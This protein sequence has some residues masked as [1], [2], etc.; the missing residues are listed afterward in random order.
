VK[1]QPPVPTPK[2]Q[3]ALR[4][5]YENKDT[6]L[7]MAWGV[8]KSVALATAGWLAATSWEP[9]LD[10]CFFAPT[11][12]QLQ[13][14]IVKA[15]TDTVARPGAYRLI[16]SGTNP[17]I[18]I[19][20]PGG[21]TS[22]IYLISGEE[23]AAARIEGL[24][25]AWVAGDELQDISRG[26]WERVA[27]RARL[28]AAK[29]LR[30]FGGGLPE[31]G[32]WLE[33]VLVID[34]QPDLVWVRGKSE[35]NPHNNDDYVPN[36][37]RTL[38]PNLFRSRALGEFAP[39]S[40]LVHPSFSRDK[41]VKPC[42]YTP[43]F[44]LI[45]GQDFNNSPMASVL[46]QDVGGETRVIG[47]IVEPGTTQD[48]AARLVKWC[49]DR[50]VNHRDPTQCVVVPDASGSARNHAGTSD[51]GLLKAAG[52]VLDGPAANPAIRDRDNAVLARLETA[53]GVR[54]LALDPSCKKTIAALAGLKHK[55][56]DRSEH[57]HP[58]DALGYPIH[59]YHPIV[60]ST[61]GSVRT[62]GH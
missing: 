12:G 10:G 17:R 1:W 4:A 8:G 33:D 61:A 38:P 23:H 50:K 62:T 30:R 18:E 47:E 41:H 57:S 25:L 29:R 51:H 52:F 32:T 22:T 55:G 31:S 14:T 11:L 19:P 2:Q 49:Q 24:N 48:Q 28:K 36:L 37:L 16:A 7:V 59:R 54:R 56:R 5:I 44:Q 27:G 46:M 20:I 35:D 60:S 34:P 42:S 3:E 26:V 58:V 43:G 13:R 40:G 9:G 21:R 39:P 15:F 6:L 53:D 45:I